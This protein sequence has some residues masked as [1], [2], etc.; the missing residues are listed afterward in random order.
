MLPQEV[1]VKDWPIKFSFVS[2]IE[3][4]R[5]ILPLKLT[6][7]AWPIRFS[8]VFSLYIFSKQVLYERATKMT[9]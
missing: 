5:Q 7:E 3:F 1:T 4:K 8:L 9:F 2:K 6:I